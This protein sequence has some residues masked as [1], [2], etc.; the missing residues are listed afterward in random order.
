VEDRLDELD[1]RLDAVEGDL[2]EL[3]GGHFGG[4]VNDLEDR[5]GDLERALGKGR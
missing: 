2:H 1:N 5:V 4:K 3:N